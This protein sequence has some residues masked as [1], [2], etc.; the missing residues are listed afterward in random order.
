MLRVKG[1]AYL[2]IPEFLSRNAWTEEE[3]VERLYRIKLLSWDFLVQRTLK[4]R[5]E[6]GKVKELLKD[7]FFGRIQHAG[8][9]H[10]LACADGVG[11]FGYITPLAVTADDGETPWYE[12]RI[13]D[14]FDDLTGA[15]THSTHDP[16]GNVLVCPE[17]G[18]LPLLA[19]TGKFVCPGLFDKDRVR[20]DR[21]SA[22][23]KNLVRYTLLRAWRAGAERI[24]AYTLDDTIGFHESMDAAVMGPLR[25]RGPSGKRRA[26]VLYRPS[27]IAR[28]IGE[29]S[30]QQSRKDRSASTR[31]E[32]KVLRATL[33]EFE[34]LA[35]K[36]PAQTANL[37]DPNVKKV[38]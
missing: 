1:I 10:N 18:V 6:D 31:R 3:L 8:D 5:I 7:Q 35:K 36:R 24:C 28:Q 33:N 12:N 32:M 30:R 34:R 27:A 11:P 13:F 29:F 4:E 37:H 16:E 14:F 17:V 19:H 9:L 26:L 22:I 38:S 20:N 23:G 25:G 15:G 21:I 2:S